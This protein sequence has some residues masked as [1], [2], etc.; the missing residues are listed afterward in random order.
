DG[1]TAPDGWSVRDRTDDGG[2]AF[3]DAGERG[4]LTGGSGA[5]AIADSDRLG[6]DRTQDTDLVTPTVDLRDAPA[7]VLR[8]HSDWRAVG[9]TDAADVDVSTDDGATWA[10]VWHQTSSRRGPLL[11][12]VPLGPAAGA[13]AVRVRFRFHGTFAWWWQVDDVQVVNRDCVPVTGGLLLGVTTDRNTGNPLNGVAVVSADRPADRGTS[14]STP[15]DPTLPDGFYWL[16][17]GLTGAH[18][19]AAGRTPY[20]AS[21][22]TATVIAH[23]AR[24]LDV[25][26]AAGRL[27]VTPSSVQSYQPYGS[28]RTT[29]VTVRNTGSAPAA[30]NLVERGGRFDMLSRAGAPL[31]EQKIKGISKAR[32]G[33]AYGGAGTTAAPRTQDAWTGIA[34]LPAAVYDN[35]AATLDGRVY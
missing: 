33:T 23:D 8:F 15:D 7:P 4:N 13:S 24:R 35:A 22:K 31:R 2:W 27:T 14:A 1:G 9:V 16:F 11:E 29:K 30:V 17:S 28:N 12:E 32:A 5:F 25:A 19:F 21:T 26:L 18:P 34:D 10:T 6:S 20:Q 3:T